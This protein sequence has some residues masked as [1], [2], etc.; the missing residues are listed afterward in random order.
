[1]RAGVLTGIWG[2]G[3]VHRTARSAMFNDCTA[4]PQSVTVATEERPRI[5]VDLS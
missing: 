1:M 5:R 4:P 3:E 2:A